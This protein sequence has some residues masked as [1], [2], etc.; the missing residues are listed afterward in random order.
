MVHQDR[1]PDKMPQAPRP[2]GSDNGGNSRGV[3]AEKGPSAGHRPQLADAYSLGRGVHAGPALSQQVPLLRGG[4]GQGV[5]SNPTAGTC[6]ARRA[7]LVE[8]FGRLADRL[9]T[10]RVCCGHWLRV[11][12]SDS[13]TV[14]LGTTGVFLDPPYSHDVARML[15]WVAYLDG[16]G[17]EP[18]KAGG[19]TNRAKDLYAN[20]RAQ[21]V[22]RLVAEVHRYCRDRGP[23]PRMRIALCGYAGEHD[24]LESLGW[25]CVA[26]TAAGGYGNRKKAN[27]NRE[28][29]RLWLSPHT[30]GRGT[31][32]ARDLPGQMMLDLTTEDSP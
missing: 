23:D 16:T 7:W 10:V 9:R 4:C 18:P 11:C 20:D 30:I 15:A 31:D 6:A 3:H 28:R 22:D 19:A 29:E 1:V 27:V 8:W 25:E 14:R 5:T 2:T 12:D 24:A 26:W 17:P 32:P 13:T 21:D